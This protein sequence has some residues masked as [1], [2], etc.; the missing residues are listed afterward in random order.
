VLARMT[1][2]VAIAAAVAA[3][4]GTRFSRDKGGG[5]SGVACAG[6]PEQ[7]QRVSR[8]GAGNQRCCISILSMSG[9]TPSGCGGGRK[10]MS[11]S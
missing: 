6:A 11:G 8:G 5:S 2:V 1:A 7:A 10:T 3:G 9:M 4:R